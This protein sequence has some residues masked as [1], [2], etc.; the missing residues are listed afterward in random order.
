MK[1]RNSLLVFLLGLGLIFSR[2]AAYATES[3]SGNQVHDRVFLSIRKE[4]MAESYGSGAVANVT[5]SLSDGSYRAGQMIPVEVVFTE[6]VFVSGTP[7]LILATGNP[8]ATA[9]DYSDGSG[10]DTLIFNYTVAAGNNSLDLDYDSVNAL[11]LNGGTITDIDANDVHLELVPPG[12]ATSLGANKSIIVDTTPPAVSFDLQSGSDTGTS[13]TDNLTNAATLTFDAN[14]TEAVSGFISQDLSNQGSSSGCTFT[15]GS[16]TSNVYPVTASGCSAGTVILR[17]AAS[18]V[19]DSAGNPNSQEDGPTVTID[20]T[21]PT[22][23]MSSTSGNPTNLSSIPVTITFSHAVS[24]FAAGDIVPTNGTVSN[25]SGSG[26]SYSFSLIPTAQGLVSANIS[27]GVAQDTAGNLNTAAATFSRTFDNSAPSV[28]MSSTAAN[29]T[30]TSPIPVKV[31][32]SETVSGFVSGDITPTNGTIANFS[33][34]GAD[35]DFDLLPTGQGTVSANI[36]AG[37]AQDSAGNNN[38]AA[39]VFSRVYD[40]LPPT[41]TFDLQIGSDTGASN[42]DNI[43][44]STTMVFDANFNE[45]ISGFTLADLS[46]ADGASGCVFAVG[47]PTG[48]T[49]P[50]TVSSCS[51]GTLILR[52]AAG[53][54]T[55]TAGNTNIQTDGPGVTIDRTGPTMSFDLQSTSDMGPSSTDNLTNDTSPVFDALFTETITGLAPADI[56]NTGTST[57]CIF[58]VGAP[59]GS[60]YPVTASG[61]SAGTLIVRLAAGGVADTAG[62]TN[63][64]TNGPTVTLD[65]TAPTVSLDLQT[66]SDTGISNTDNST[67]ATAPIFD[68][69]FSEAVSGFEAADLSNIGTATACTF[70]IGSPTG[71]TYPVT[72]TGCSDGTLIIRVAANGVMDLAGNMNAQTDG[73]VVTV[74]RTA[75]AV[76]FDLRTTS[77]TGASNSDNLTNAA[78]LVFDAAFTEAITDFINTDLSNTGTS[79]GCTFAIGTPTGN[80]YPVTVS[81]CTAGTVILRLAASGVTD[82]AGNLSAQ[83]D[84]PVVTIDRTLPVFSAVAP[85]ASTQINSITAAS[86][87]SFTISETLTSGTVTMTR[88]GGSND[89]TVHTCT[90]IGT[91]L[92]AGPHNNLDMSD[93]VNGCTAAQSLVGDAIYTFRFNGTDLAGNAAAA[94]SRTN[95]TF[96]NI[97]PTIIIGA[98]SLT[99]TNTGPVTFTI[100]YTDTHFNTSTLALGNITINKTS[101]ATGTASVD[102]GTGSIRTVTL[103]G[104]EGNGTIGIS[105]AAG[106]A[107]DLAGNLAP[108]STAS[109]TFIVDNARPSNNWTQPVGNGASYT[110]HD[111]LVTLA[112][113]ASDSNGMSRVEFKRYDPINLVF[114]D[115]GT[116]F[117]PPYQLQ[118]DTSVLTKGTNYFY[119]YAYDLAGN[120]Q[121]AYIVMDHYPTLHVTTTGSG[122]G[123][124]TSSPSGINCGATCTSDY[125]NFVTIVTLTAHP[126]SPSYF[127]GWSGACTGTGS[128]VL[129]MDESK[130]V[131][132]TFTR[133]SF[134]YLPM[135]LR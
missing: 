133:N 46:N 27:A 5:S 14:F 76:T 134:I 74:D 88:T 84:G 18:A 119:S 21:V 35:Y 13:N 72:V 130:F 87:V 103:S 25:F 132:A 58:A 7:Q 120:L 124:V 23:G 69:I 92:T 99:I 126:V 105:I 31:V 53:T 95:V 102:S 112:V 71:N 81:A 110:V 37:A 79:T 116:V 19:I 115:I 12:H 82:T 98:P 135:I 113:N 125:N 62:N 129:T 38:T 66:A 49:Y 111:Q 96:D 67:F 61:C 117:S 59:S 118:F 29:P 9:V 42:T 78:A 17:L 63:I 91:G 122:S 2:A 6:A 43:T 60:T 109:T 104:T 30:R 16:E 90:F 26:A 83:T 33:G 65:I 8:A 55:D 54:V 41:V 52:L 100:T 3:N 36:A 107:S 68:A 75:P 56:T 128:C 47:S 22:V 40:T 24:G 97:P 11:D 101:S 86:D 51:E 94:V 114:I 106:T 123:S 108:A 50:V 28:S 127:T 4:N 131:T 32:F 73:P 48:T 34:S 70:A 85:T 15:V 1:I 10:S 20:R 93:I 80:I 64:L 89:G 45:T 39:P 44:N 57:G 121:N 77:D